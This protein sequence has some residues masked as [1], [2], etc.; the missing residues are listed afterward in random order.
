MNETR[1][2]AKTPGRPR[3][4]FLGVP[5]SWRALLLALPF[6]ACVSCAPARPAPW[7]SA[8]R[9]TWA[10][11]R[12]ALD[13]QRASRSRAPWAAGLHVTMRDPRSGRVVDGRGAIAVAPG[14]AVRMILIGAAGA[15]MLDAWVTRA[16]WRVAVPPLEVVRRGGLEDP[17][18]MPVGFLRWWFLTPLT[19][20]LFAATFVADGGVIW[21]LREGGAVIELREGSCSRGSLLRATRRT[22]GHGE[23]VDE[24]RESATPRVGDTA[25]YID[26][27]SGLRVEVLLESIATA[28][29]SADA[30]RDPDSLGAGT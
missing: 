21:L 6:V 20:T 19:G 18:D 12:R 2:L 7:P 5:V 25:R 24:C 26:E 22:H 10:G 28:P 11:L 29:P 17:P 15:T 16:H 4:P 30:F 8:T 3:E 9:Q 13:Q 14:E 27:A 23:A 1:E